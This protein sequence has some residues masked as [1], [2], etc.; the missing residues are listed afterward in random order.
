VAGKLNKNEGKWLHL[1]SYRVFSVSLEYDHG[2][3]KDFGSKLV[4]S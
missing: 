3:K 2:I 4:I 1:E